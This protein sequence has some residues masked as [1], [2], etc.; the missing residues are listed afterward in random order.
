MRM[1]CV[2]RRAA[3]ATSICWRCWTRRRRGVALGDAVGEADGDVLKV[4]ESGQDQ[5]RSNGNIIKAIVENQWE[6]ND[7][8][9]DKTAS[10]DASTQ[11][12]AIEAAAIGKIKGEAANT[13]L[14]EAAPLEPVVEA[15]AEAEKAALLPRPPAGP[16]PAGQ[17]PR[18]GAARGGRANQTISQEGGNAKL[19][20]T[21]KQRVS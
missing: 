18:R 3:H 11:V 4:S 8:A 1:Q 13:L 20:R 17:R 12:A 5:D 2:W 10:E 9:V 19:R 6:D 21:Q 15:E 16:P 7:I 14:Q